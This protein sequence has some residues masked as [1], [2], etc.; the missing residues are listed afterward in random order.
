MNCTSGSTSDSPWP[1]SPSTDPRGDR[2]PAGRSESRGRPSHVGPVEPRRLPR[3][4][5][6]APDDSPRGIAIGT[7]R[8]RAMLLVE[9]AL[10][11]TAFIYNGARTRTAQ[12]R[13]ARRGAAGTPWGAR[14]TARAAATPCASP[15]RGR[16]TH[17]RSDSAPTRTPG[18]RCRRVGRT[19]SRRPA[20]RH[21]LHS[22][23]VPARDRAAVPPRR[24]QRRRDRVVRRTKRLPGVPTL[25]GQARVRVKHRPQPGERATG[26][27]LLTTSPSS[28]VG[29]PATRRWVGLAQAGNVGPN[30]RRSVG[31]HST[32]TANWSPS[33]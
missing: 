9:L 33:R 3:G 26:D 28:T 4:H 14:A 20:R 18:C 8:A 29:S 2:Q 17:R 1:R 11:G 31:G 12:R 19:D 13:A 25:E 24:V 22:G 10:P 16:V 30:N 5:R 23:A 6:Y 7:D 27:V 15:S 21:L 32:V